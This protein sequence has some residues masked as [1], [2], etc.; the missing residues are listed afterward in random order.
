MAA[1]SREELPDSV[2]ILRRVHRSQVVGTNDGQ[3]VR[4]DS[5]TFKDRRGESVSAYRADVLSD[6]GHDPVDEVLDGYGQHGV[7]SLEA[8]FIRSQGLEI[9]EDVD[10]NDA[11]CGAAHV[12][13]VGQKSHTTQVRLAEAC[14][15]ERRPPSG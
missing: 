8:G 14:N 9:H 5:S 1:L 2:R 15:W 12:L 3:D 4:P 7:A 13:I 6:I 11:S 10:E